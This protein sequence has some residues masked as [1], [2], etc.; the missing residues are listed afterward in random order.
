M[1]DLQKSMLLILVLIAT[2]ARNPGLN[3]WFPPL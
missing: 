2:Q 3:E 1:I